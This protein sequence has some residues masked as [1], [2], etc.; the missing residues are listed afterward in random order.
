[1]P[2]QPSRVVKQ[3]LEQFFAD[4]PVQE[5]GAGEV[6]LPVAQPVE[7]IFFLKSGYVR[8]FLT[9]QAGIE[10]TVHYFKPYSYFPL[11]PLLAERENR[12]GFVA[13]TD[14]VCRVA[15][16]KPVLEFICHDLDI[17]CDLNV[18]FASAIDGLSLRLEYTYFYPALIQTAN[19]INFLAVEFG[20]V[21]GEKIILDRHFTHQQLADWLGLARETVSRQIEKLKQQ[22]IIS[23]R[24][25]QMVILDPAGL[26]QLL[27]L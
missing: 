25:H 1:M 19:L 5:Y 7:Q 24:G 15:P 6:I 17:N 22:G 2:Y 18:R 4:Y 8:Q 26:Q 23:Y 12:F 21:E 3:K 16:V 14:C 20:R 27:Q 13:L 9:S 10:L 11:I